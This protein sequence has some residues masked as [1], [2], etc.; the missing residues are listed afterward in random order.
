M[1]AVATACAAAPLALA[2]AGSN[3]AAPEWIDYFNTHV[4]ATCVSGL[5]AHVGKERVVSTDAQ[6]TLSVTHT[7]AGV[8]VRYSLATKVV[9]TPKPQVSS[10]VP[11]PRVLSYTFRSDGTVAT[12]PGNFTQAPFAYTWSEGEVYP[13]LAQIESGASRDGVL[14]LTLTPTTAAARSELSSYLVP[15]ARTIIFALHYRVTPAPARA[16]AVTPAGTFHNLV[17]IVFTVTGTTEQNLTASGKRIFGSV[18]G[19]VGSLVKSDVYFAPGE[20]PVLS[21]TALGPAELERC[22]G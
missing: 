1:I 21:E 6:R 4:G 12:N 14:D 10:L 13:T 8:V 19:A 16:T 22:S 5:T 18:L 17:G 3:A 11:L 7:A 2:A 20:G 9:E 15:G